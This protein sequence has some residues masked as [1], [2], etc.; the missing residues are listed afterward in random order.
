MA[1]R[2]PLKLTDCRH[3]HIYGLHVVECSYCMPQSVKSCFVKPTP[4]RFD[5][6]KAQGSV[7]PELSNR[8]AFDS[9]FNWQD[10]KTFRFD[11]VSI[12]YRFNSKTI[13]FDTKTALAVMKNIGHLEIGQFQRGIVHKDG[14][15]IWQLTF[16]MTFI[17]TFIFHYLS[18]E[19]FLFTFLSRSNQIELYRKS[20]ISF[21]SIC[22]RYKQ[23]LSIRYKQKLSIRYK[24]KL[25]IQYKQKLSI[26]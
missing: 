4:T 23:K 3:L 17:D 26:R 21:D 16:V 1:P 22:I 12:W 25:S 5:Q 7:E 2:L 19:F 9:I 13:R 11:S 6:C 8:I 20:K 18:S 24:Q 14:G 10:A 15:N